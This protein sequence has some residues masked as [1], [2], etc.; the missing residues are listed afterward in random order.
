MD[1][2]ATDNSRSLGVQR[3]SVKDGNYNARAIA[4]C[5]RDIFPNWPAVVGG[6]STKRY[7]LSVVEKAFAQLII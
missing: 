6:K 7:F 4:L 5:S 2:L 1:H 3:F